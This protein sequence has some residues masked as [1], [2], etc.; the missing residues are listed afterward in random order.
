[1]E[2]T[3]SLGTEKPAPATYH[4]AVEQLGALTELVGGVE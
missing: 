2:Q 4:S 3:Q 1:M